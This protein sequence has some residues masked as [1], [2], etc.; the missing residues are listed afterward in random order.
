MYG[1]T[2]KLDIAGALA[3]LGMLALLVAGC[4]N[5]SAGTALPYSQQIL[6]MPLNAGSQDVKGLDPATVS[7]A[8]SQA[9]IQLIYPQ[10]LTLN[11]QS[12]PVPF[13][14][15]SMPVFNSADNTYT[16]TLRP[17]LKWSDGTP[18]TSQTF[19][20][21]INR[22]ESPCTGS[23][24]TYY[25]FAIKD[26]EAFSGETCTSSGAIKGPIQSL[27]GDSLLTPD[28]QTL[29][30]KLNAPAPYILG[31]FSYPTF[32][33]QPE[34]LIT[35]YGTKN[36]TA[37]LTDNGGF[38]GGMYKV[39][40]WNHTG[41]LNL[42]AN[43]TFWGAAPKLREIEFRVYATTNALYADYL[44]GKIAEGI[45]PTSQYTSAKARSDF[46]DVPFLA[47]GYYQMNWNKPPFNNLD[48]RQAF[49]LAINKEVL[50]DR[51][52][53]GTVTATNHIVPVGMYGY[54]A[55]LAAPDG[56]LT[57]TGDPSKAEELMNNYATA[58]CPG[59][60]AG[61]DTFG[62]C[63]PVTLVDANEPDLVISDQAVLGM[64]QA[65][66][67]GYPVKTQ[68]V[69]FNT[70]VSDVLSS[71]PPQI[72]AIGWGA[73][74]PDPQDFTSLQFGPNSINNTGSVNVPA[75]NKLLAE[76]DTD[77]NPTSRAQLYNQAEQLLVNEVAWLP[78]WQQK[79]V[80]NLSPNVHNLVYNSLAFIPMSSWQT[81]FMS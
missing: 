31:A 73:D 79:T 81:I 21:S 46:H 52:N 1:D 49:D 7:D 57:L 5:S 67:P 61:S 36:W 29:V 6:I 58:N 50:A 2:R 4:G 34:Q 59:Y 65:A 60:K 16:F 23:P 74:Y 35:R 20:Y 24:V 39:S 78:L 66:L 30:I 51:V 8:Y 28:N 56:T 45:P 11:A 69:D 17:N 12:E 80:Y 42:V 41:E 77:L 44:D 76:A 53:D 75:A 19:A 40:L 47:I 68:F 72:W 62:T 15:V 14:A 9:P 33:A 37:H 3:L 27:I 43:S 63:P 54:D 71:S 18:I 32:Y 48:A 13:A 25:M 38:G 64:W 26:A 10:L 55:N 22:S 70:L